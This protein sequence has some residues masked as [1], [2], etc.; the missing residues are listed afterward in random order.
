M[1]KADV[2]LIG[3]GIVG[4]ATA[5][6]LRKQRP[7]LTLSILEKEDDVAKHQTGHNSGVVHTGIYY[8]PGSLKATNCLRGKKM[9]LEFCDQENIPYKK[10]T[11][12]IVATKQEEVSRME[13]LFERGQANGLN[14][15]KV[16][17]KEEAQER[18]P[19]INVER[20]ILNEDCHIISYREVALK[21]K[22][23]L[24][25]D[26]VTFFFQEKVVNTTPFENN[27]LIETDRD[28]HTSHYV[29]NCAGL[30]SDRLAKASDQIVPFRGEYYFLT[31]EVKTKVES[32]IYPV[33]NPQL[34][35]LGVHITPMI[36]GRVEAGPNAVLAFA[37]E[38]YKKTIVKPTELLQTLLF[39]GFWKISSKHFSTGLYEMYR[40]FSKKAF[41]KSLQELMPSLTEADIIPGGSGVRAQLVTKK[42]ALC[43]DFSLIK[44]N[45][46][47]HVLNAP[48]PAATASFA[49]GEHIVNSLFAP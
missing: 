20:A 25:N 12:L 7:E 16:I 8:K 37:R 10:T 47:M 2:T 19:Y 4:L 18:E 35:F 15:I 49:I 46:M 6:A 40:S 33:P 26:G 30:Y 38:G 3:G 28:V 44:D 11:K 5:F 22:Q 17:G 39:P 13:T 36:D 14:H 24:Q 45:T 32:L 21:L 29:I 41:L 27:W 1:K 42:G 31:E 48:S 43:D 9:L 34:P 23:K